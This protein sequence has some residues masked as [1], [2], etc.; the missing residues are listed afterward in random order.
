VRSSWMGMF[1]KRFSGDGVNCGGLMPWISSQVRQRMKRKST[2]PMPP[3]PLQGYQSNSDDIPYSLTSHNAV[4]HTPQP[5]C[6]AVLRC[7]HCKQ[8]LPNIIVQPIS[9]LRNG[10]FDDGSRMLHGHLGHDFLIWGERECPGVDI[11][12]P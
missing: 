1:M 11:W 7:P 8:L 12:V 4:Y 6:R 2:N 5:T 10:V 9:H 3:N